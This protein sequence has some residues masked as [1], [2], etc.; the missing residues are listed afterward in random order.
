[1]VMKVHS[2]LES[3]D[4][5]NDELGKIGIRGP[6]GVERKGYYPPQWGRFGG[7]LRELLWELENLKY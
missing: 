2:H 3:W 1:M 6:G 5:F 4:K 7:A